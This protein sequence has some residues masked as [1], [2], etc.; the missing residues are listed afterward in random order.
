V[1]FY[2]DLFINIYKLAMAYYNKTLKR[3]QKGGDKSKVIESPPIKDVETLIDTGIEH[4][5]AAAGKLIIYI[6]RLMID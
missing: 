6:R 4:A 5:V 1:L 3:N 2:V